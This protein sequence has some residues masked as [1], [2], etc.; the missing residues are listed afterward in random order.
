MKIIKINLIIILLFL[1]IN[2]IDSQ[3]VNCRYYNIKDS[4]C[5]DI[6]EN[7]TG[8]TFTINYF[9]KNIS[10]R[11]LKP[12]SWVGYSEFLR[13]LF[14]EGSYKTKNNLI[15]CYDATVRRYYTFKKIDNYTLVATKH[16]ALFTK[17]DT[18]KLYYV[19]NG[20]DNQIQ[21]MT[22][23]LGNRDGIWAN[24]YIG[25]DS[26]NLTEY[27]NNIIVRQ[28]RKKNKDSWK[29]LLYIRPFGNVSNL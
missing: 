26:I 16:T 20:K 5:L 13:F 17:G 22:W 12:I 10:N 9:K 4:L 25:S 11:N 19:Y 24:Y 7:N 23:K 14:S 29:T 6:S 28:Y 18:L 8:K 27:K 2:T 15:I 1:T 3:D 21:G